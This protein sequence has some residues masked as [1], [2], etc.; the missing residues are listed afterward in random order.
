M[1]PPRTMTLPTQEELRKLLRYNSRTGRLFWKKRPESM[2]KS[3]NDCRA[4]NARFAGK[5]AF[6]HVN[7]MHRRGLI[8]RQSIYAHQ[9]IWRMMTGEAPAEI[10]HINGNPL[11]NRWRNLRVA[12]NGAN[13]KNS[14]RRSDNKSGHAGV[15]RRGDQWIAQFGVNGTTKHIGIYKT[16]EAAIKARKLVER[17]YG[18]HRNHGRD[19]SRET[20]EEQ[21]T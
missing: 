6:T 10:D 21:C 5:E 14:K 7:H 16:K 2:F 11:D 3:T 19:V 1:A 9:V 15:V 4:W 12:V 13:Q 20:K 18:F 8:F 17:E